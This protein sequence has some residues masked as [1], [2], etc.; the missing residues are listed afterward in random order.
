MGLS[1]HVVGLVAVGGLIAVSGQADAATRVA[2]NFGT[3]RI[4]GGVEHRPS[5]VPRGA[6]AMKAPPPLQAPPPLPTPPPVVPDAK[7][8]GPAVDPP[9]PS[10]PPDGPTGTTK[11]KSKKRAYRYDERSPEGGAATSATPPFA[12]GDESRPGGVERAPTP[13]E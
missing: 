3:E 11:K 9:E 8:P 1:R 2:Q 6:P 10:P 13:K 5:S 4:P 12:D 7:A